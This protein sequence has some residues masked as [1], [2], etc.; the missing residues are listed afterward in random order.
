MGEDTVAGREEGVSSGLGL[1]V[2][3]NGNGG[4]I[5]DK[6]YDWARPSKDVDHLIYRF[7]R[8]SSFQP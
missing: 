8:R 3:A 1:R 4:R 5:C 2:R 7:G 6:I